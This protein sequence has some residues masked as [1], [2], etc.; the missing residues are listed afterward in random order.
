[1]TKCFSNLEKKS[2]SFSTSHPKRTNRTAVQFCG[3]R[4]YWL[5]N[6][7]FCW[8][9]VTSVNDC[10]AYI[11][12]VNMN[13]VPAS[14]PFSENII[15]LHIVSSSLLPSSLPIRSILLC[16]TNPLHGHLHYSHN[17]SLLVPLF[18]P[19]GSSLFTIL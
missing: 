9:L 4:K 8:S 11:Y 13:T 6:L 5:C 17:S 2:I 3:R 10:K 7:N 18:L 12:G 16:H 1:M 14:N 15:Y 19:L